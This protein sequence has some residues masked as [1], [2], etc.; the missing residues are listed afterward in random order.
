MSDLPSGP[1]FTADVLRGLGYDSPSAAAFVP[2]DMEE[3]H[4]REAGKRSEV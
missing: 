1:C 2:C 3:Q 4:I